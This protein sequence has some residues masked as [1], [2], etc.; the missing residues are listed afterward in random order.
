MVFMKLLKH[1]MGIILK[2]YSKTN[3]CF[4]YIKGEIIFMKNKFK[5]KI[6]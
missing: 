2:E 5:F 1:L 4:A 6:K 3:F